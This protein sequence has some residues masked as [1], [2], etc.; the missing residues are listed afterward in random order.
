[1][2]CFYREGDY[3]T[4]AFDGQVARLRGS[5]GLSL[6][7]RLVERPGREVHVLDLSDLHT[8]STVSPEPVLDGRGRRVFRDRIAELEAEMEEADSYADIERSA[9]ARIEF[10]A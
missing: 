1:M 10:D 3:W 2:N 8:F 6:L 9:S 7:G 4:V 5:R